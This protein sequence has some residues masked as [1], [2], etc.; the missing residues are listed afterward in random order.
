MTDRSSV[1]VSQL[2]SYISSLLK[3]DQFLNDISVVGEVSGLTITN[4][5]I[6]FSLKDD[7]AILKC[8]VFRNNF[9]KLVNLID[10]GKKIHARGSVSV[11]EKSS[12][13]QFIVRDIK[14]DGEGEL[15]K[16]YLELKAK[17]E[18]EGLFDNKHKK[19]LPNFPSKLGI[20]TSKTGAA[21]HDVLKVL[22]RRYPQINISLFPALVQGQFSSD[23]VIRGLK[24]F[25]NEYPVDLILVTRG[26]GS[27]EDLNSFNDEELVRY[28]YTMK[29]PL[30]AA[31]GHQIDS[32]LIEYV[33]DFRAATPTEAAELISP[34]NLDMKNL[35]V[36]KISRL[37]RSSLDK[38]KE[39]ESELSHLNSRLKNTHP[40][41]KYE[42]YLEKLNNKKNYMD[43]LFK[44]NLSRYE[45]N[46]D[47]YFSKLASFDNSKILQRGY[48]ITTKNGHLIKCSLEVKEGDSIK[49]YLSNGEIESK[50]ILR[51]HNEDWIKRL[52]EIFK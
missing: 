4:S 7:N 10:E 2:S 37:K 16:K 12:S 3:R 1:K 30:V 9:T 28:A 13:Y 6:Y 38:Y 51:S 41:F 49:T 19:S 26:G 14:V 29:T 23:S 44:G 39:I 35:L 47:V 20:I 48:S 17:L 21:Y 52:W 27:F 50:V 24:F 5:I 32:S 43:L 42:L 25:E 45:N 8:I 36:D 33:A 34:S 22:S 46:L 11:Y 31:I 18:K 15:F 40:L